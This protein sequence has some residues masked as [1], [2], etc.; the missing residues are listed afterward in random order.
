MKSLRTVKDSL[1]RL[2]TAKENFDYAKEYYDTVRKKENVVISNY[3]FSELP[4]GSKSFDIELDDGERFYKDKKT[5]SVCTYRRTTVT[6]LID[7]LKETFP[8]KTFN[9]FVDK[10]YTI[11]N[12]PG[13]IEYLKTCNVDPA[14]FKMFVDV[15]CTV[16]KEKLDNLYNLG[17]V[18][19]KQLRDCYIIEYGDPCVRMTE[20]KS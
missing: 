4:K 3:I 16:N 12:M 1:Y 10:T 9:K 17:E 19:K 2:Y 8:K 14:V 20:K 6:W 13:L 11:N 5:F 15:E 7:K 18:T